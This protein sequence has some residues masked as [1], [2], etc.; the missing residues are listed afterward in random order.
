[1]D[2]QIL[3]NVHPLHRALSSAQRLWYAAEYADCLR[4]LESE[5]PSPQRFLLAAWASYRRRTY[6]EALAALAAGDGWFLSAFDR[7]EADALSA[8]LHELKGN[9]RESN[10][11]ADRVDRADPQRKHAP[12]QNMLALRAWVRNDLSECLRRVRAGETDVDPNVRSYAVSL[13][14]WAHA[15]RG[16]LARQAELLL[17]T[18]NIVL[19]AETPDVGHAAET[20]Q[21]LSALCRERYMPDQFRAVESALAH[22]PWTG[23]L[24]RQQYNTLRHCAWTYALQGNYVQGLRSLRKAETL[25][26]NAAFAALSLLDAAWIEHASREDHAAQAHLADALEAIAS[27]DW[28]V[29]RGDEARALL[30]AAEIAANF[31]PFAARKA[32]KQYDAAK[33]N[34]SLRYGSRHDGAFEAVERFTR[35]TVL[36]ASA[37]NSTARKL[38]KQAYERFA[39]IGYEWRAARCAL[40]LYEQGCGD[41]WLAAARESAAHYPRSF[42]GARLARLDADS[43]EGPLSKLTPKQR[44]VVARLVAG[45]T[46]EAAAVALNSSANTVKVHVKHIHRVLGVRNRAELINAVRRA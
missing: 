26:P 24:R 32:L 6:D 42:I 46:I 21:T 20:L 4:A 13:R 30:L 39:E 35:A 34:V 12:A 22:F 41:V 29:Q 8:A 37:E 38:A 28:S 1:M 2:A 18:L 16:Q 33:P 27:I 40:F 7:A 17:E 23:D 25:A 14:A 11:F 45:D 43:S 9:R 10:A 36:A 31:D 19:S 44:D 3:R 15:S 5:P